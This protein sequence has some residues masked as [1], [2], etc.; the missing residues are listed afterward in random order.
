MFLPLTIV[1][2]RVG[3]FE[4][5]VVVRSPKIRPR[6]DVE[7][8]QPSDHDQGRIIDFFFKKKKCRDPSNQ[9]LIFFFF[10]ELRDYSLQS[11]RAPLRVETPFYDPFIF[12][13]F[14]YFQVTFFCLEKLSLLANY[15]Y[16]K[17]GLQP[18]LV[19]AGK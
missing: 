19:G 4:F 17:L 6:I 13:L 11:L 8:S 10:F 1:I 3:N 12:C 18:N 7:T 2:I 16:I 5:K 14:I 15:Y 9:I